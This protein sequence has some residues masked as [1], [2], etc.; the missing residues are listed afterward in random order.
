MANRRGAYSL[1]GQPEG[2]I[3]IGRPRTIFKLIFNKWDDGE[4]AGLICFR[5]GKGGGLL[6][7]W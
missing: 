3:A 5:T 1:A 7:M 2:R 4:W 6:L